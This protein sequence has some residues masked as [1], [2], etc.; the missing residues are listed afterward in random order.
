MAELVNSVG[1]D[2]LDHGN[3]GNLLG[4]GEPYRFWSTHV[5]DVRVAKLQLHLFCSGVDSRV[6][7]RVVQLHRAE[8]QCIG[9]FRLWRMA[10]AHASRAPI[11][12][13]RVPLQAA[14]CA[15]R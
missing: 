10:S 12:H 6:S 1:D 9:C 3:A 5:S 14:L 8:L 13:S 7:G 15:I 2:V 4:S 11:S